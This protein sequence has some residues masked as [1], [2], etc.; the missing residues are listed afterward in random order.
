M[1]PRAAVRAYLQPATFL[2]SLEKIALEHRVSIVIGLTHAL[3]DS[4]LHL[5]VRTPELIVH[6]GMVYWAIIPAC[7]TRSPADAVNVSF[8][9]PL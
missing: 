5:V 3:S 2:N 6:T 9:R 4:S 8:F 1:F 7:S